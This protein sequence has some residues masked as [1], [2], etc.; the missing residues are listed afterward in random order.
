MWK[1][2]FE[3]F[4]IHFDFAYRSF[5]WDSEAAEKAHVHCVIIGFSTD[6]ASNLKKR[7]FDADQITEAA[8]INPYLVDAQNVF[9][10]ARRKPLE[11]VSEMTRGS[12]PTD[13]GNLIL[14]IEEKEALLAVEPQAAP[15]VRPFMMGKDFIDRKPRFCL[16]MVGANPSLLKKCPQVQKR[17]EAVREF[18]LA[19][20]KPATRKKAETPSLFDEVK[21]CATDF[22]ALPVVSS[23]NRKYIP[24]DYLDSNIIAGNKL[25]M[26][27]DATHYL[28]GVL[29]SSVHMAW[30]RA[31]AGRLKSDYSYSNTVVYNNF[32][33]PEVTEKQR[34]KITE[35]AKEI[36]DVRAKY[37]NSSLADL[38]DESTMPVDLRKAHKANDKAV[39]AAYGFKAN[40]RESEVVTE[41]FRRYEQCVKELENE[42][43][44][45]VSKNAVKKK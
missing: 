34:E 37:P 40:T 31:V 21:Q 8:N 32:V 6:S 14:T 35:T 41:L 33:W 19:S 10:E 28:F 29:T 17:I 9:I 45:S 4:G 22:L 27:P 42:S 12:Q 3:R 26:V 36:L 20:K 11:S 25:F 44:K 38:Y 5:V 39:M 15:F 2:L 13:D 23:E 43:T 18:R 30:M 16:W 24:I 7:I 1:P